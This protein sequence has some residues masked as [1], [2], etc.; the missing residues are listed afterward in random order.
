[1]PIIKITAKRQATFSK[2]LC[3]DLHVG[4]GDSIA[5]ERRMLDG[6]AVW[7]LRPQ[8]VDWSWVGSVKVPANAS[9]DID[10]VRASIAQSRRRYR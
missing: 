3:D 6:E 5:V 10:D 1:M 4:P 2:E 8:T 9:H 7:I